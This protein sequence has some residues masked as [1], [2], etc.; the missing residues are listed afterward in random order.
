MLSIHIH[1][2]DGRSVIDPPA[3][4]LAK[5]RADPGA[6][7]WVDLEAPNQDELATV[8][9][10]FGLLDLTVEDLLKQGQRAKLEP[11]EGYNVLIMHGMSFD[12]TTREVST[13]EVDIVLGKNFVVT[14]HDPTLRDIVHDPQGP[15]HV[16]SQL[17]KSPTLLVY[18]IVDR[19]VDAYFPVLDTI[20]D[21]IEEVEE[22]VLTNPTSDVLGHIFTLKHSLGTLRK[23]VSPQLEVFNRLIAREDAV[24]DPGYA[25]YFRDIYDHLVRCFE[26]VDSYRDLMSSSMDA[27]LSMVANRQNELIQRLTLFATIFMPITFL[28]G[29]F[30]QN[31]RVMPQV[32]HDNGYLWWYVLGFMIM[33]SVGQILYYRRKRWL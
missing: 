17:A 1:T 25:V 16:C 15:N 11:F 18:G 23:V 13:P 2:G 31:F 6:C 4:E 27:Y 22:R 5:Y 29:L 24:I 7:I 19:L 10:A 3:T 14:G 33:L 8:A 32:E 28:T 26:I 12:P 9:S 20:D 30:G 21:A